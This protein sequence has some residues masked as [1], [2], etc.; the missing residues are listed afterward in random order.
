ME[1]QIWKA[2]AGPNEYFMIPFK[3]KGTN[4]L[5]SIYISVESYK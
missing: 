3:T 4:K 2:L 5:T 1:L